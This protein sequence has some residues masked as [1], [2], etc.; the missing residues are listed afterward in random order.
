[1]T[2][3]LTFLGKPFDLAAP[4][5]TLTARK[6]PLAQL[7]V[8]YQV[9]SRDP[10]TRSDP[11]TMGHL[12]V[13]RLDDQTTSHDGRHP[14]PQV[15]YQFIPVF[16]CLI[17]CLNLGQGL[18]KKPLYFKNTVNYAGGKLPSKQRFQNRFDLHYSLGA[19]RTDVRTSTG[20]RSFPA[21]TKGS[22]SL[23][24]CTLSK[25]GGIY[26]SFERGFHRCTALQF[27]SSISDN[28]GRDDCCNRSNC[29]NPRCC[30]LLYIEG[31]EYH[32]Q[33]PTQNANP[34]KNPQQPNASNSYFS[35]KFESSHA[36]PDADLISYKLEA[37]EVVGLPIAHRVA[38]RMLLSPMPSWR[39][40]E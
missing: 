17:D 29:L 4:R 22:G 39:P 6:R 40:F 25:V 38:G 1:M 9:P 31:I 20:S 27:M 13:F 21:R 23:V 37:K 14:G 2:Q 24:N 30:I 36:A 15:E 35:R 33:G 16:R 5:T 18:R 28:E 11:C 26:L 8:G 19:D 10:F 34:K 7:A 32:E 12:D 3:I